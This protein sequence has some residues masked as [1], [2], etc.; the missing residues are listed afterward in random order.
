MPFGKGLART[1]LGT[2]LAYTESSH[3]TKDDA[4]CFGASWLS[5]NTNFSSTRSAELLFFQK[6]V[7]IVNFART[8]DYEELREGGVCTR[9]TEYSSKRSLL[10]SKSSAQ[11]RGAGGIFSR[12]YNII[13]IHFGFV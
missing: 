2:K 12:A 6:V 9:G 3:V 11:K 13:N 4:S 7:V 8:Q 1:L 10:L 5:I